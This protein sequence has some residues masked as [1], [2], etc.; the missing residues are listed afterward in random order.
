MT[1][2]RPPVRA[3][4]QVVAGLVALGLVAG[5]CGSG[6]SDSSTNATVDKGIQ[7]GV[8]QAVGGSSTTAAGSTTSSVPE[9]KSMDEWDALWATQRDAIVKRIKDNKWGKSADG[10]T[11]TGPEGFTIDLSKCPAGWSDT[12]GLSD[13][14]IKIGQTISQSGTTADYG[15]IA[16]SMPLVFDYYGQKGAFKDAQGKSRKINYVAKDDGYDPARTIPLTDELIDSEKVF[17]VWTLGSANALKIYDKLNQRC[18]PQPFVMS[19]HPAWGDPVNHPWTTGQQLAYN[20]EA[21]LWGA[22]IDQH[23]SELETGGGKVTVAAL[24]MNNDFGKAYDLGFKAYLAQSA[25]KDKIDY[26]TETVEPQTPTVTDPMTTLQSK[27]PQIFIAMV[28]SSVCTQAVTAAAQNGMREEAKYLF[29]PNVCPGTTYVKKE[30]VGG[31]GEASDK[32]W[33]VNGGGK[34]I[35]DPNQFG[36]PAVAWMRDQLTSHGFDPK[37]SSSLGLGM[38]YGWPMV[39]A[40]QGAGQLD[41]GLTRSNFMLFLR[42]MDMTHPYVLPGIRFN[43]NGDMDAYLTEG[44][45]FQKWDVAKQ[46]WVTEGSAID[47][48]GRSKSCAWDAS[49][50]ICK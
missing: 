24:V 46:I 41:G 6:T 45:I 19:G 44:G 2:Q 3:R 39:Q 50:G 42:S 30:A 17:A 15:N 23:F 43:M 32:W 22:F 34:D 36:D 4:A 5:A 16:K 49:A 40:L 25:N 12:E 10:K 38:Y 26:V 1:V 29:Q 48:S 21:V 11:L 13:T 14:T 31:N 27:K 9:P 28:A 33:I 18:I 47:L 35:N 7:S 37:S 8:A 20:T